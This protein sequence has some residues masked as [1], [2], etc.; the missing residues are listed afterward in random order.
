MTTFC[1]VAGLHRSGTSVLARTLGAHP[2]VSAF[3]NTGVIEDEG[4][5]LQTIYPA[6]RAFGGPGKFG[7]HPDA[8]LDENAPLA[9]PENATRLFRDWR[10]HWDLRR[11]V[12][13][14][15]SPP[16]LLKTRFL[17][18]LFPQARFVVV[19]RH[20]IAT[21]LATQKWSRTTME[22]LLDHWLTCHERFRADRV[23]LNQS[24]VIRYEALVGQPKPTMNAVQT[25]LGLRPEDLT[26]QIAANHNLRYFEAWQSAV[27]DPVM[28]AMLLR[29]QDRFESRALKFGYS[30]DLERYPDG[31][32][33]PRTLKAA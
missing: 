14:E 22:S 28:G 13:L 21:S 30:L 31:I 15:K 18:R 4:Q 17:Q 9:T 23:G 29:C 1:F 27:K 6:A 10:V 16:N 24:L 3:A 26:G 33:A 20:P 2:D 32:C 8:Y 5:F 19:T 7:F 25:F 11:D 12:L